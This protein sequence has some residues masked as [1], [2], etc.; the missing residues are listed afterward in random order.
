GPAARP[1]AAR[2]RARGAASAPAPASAPAR[3]TAAD[4]EGERPEVPTGAQQAQ[5]QGTTVPFD[6]PDAPGHLEVTFGEV[7]WDVDDL[8]AETNLF[9]D[10]P[11]EG[12]RYL[13]VTL[14]ASYRGSGSFSAYVW[15]RL[16]YVAED[17]TVHAQKR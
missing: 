17:G 12:N 3:G 4:G 14:E 13:M 10:P 7:S 2:G 9:N 6:A 8:I 5:P 16:E 11:A 1:A 15:A